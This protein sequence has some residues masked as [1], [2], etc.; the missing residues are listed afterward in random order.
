[1]SSKEYIRSVGE[2]IPD[3]FPKLEPLPSPIPS[4]SNDS[5]VSSNI[6]AYLLNITWQTWL[7]LFLIISLLGINIFAYLAKG[8]E[9]SATIIKQLFGP[10]LAF[11]GYGTLDTAKQTI[12][13]TATGTKAGVDIIAGAASGA[14]NIIEENVIANAIANANGQ[15]AKSSQQGAP[16]HEQIQTGTNTDKFE[17]GSL[18]K[19]LSSASQSGSSGPEPD[20]SRSSIQ[21]TGKA[22]WCFIGEDQGGRTCS[23]VGVNDTCMSGDVFPNQD[24]CM[25]P[26]LRA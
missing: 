7:I 8:T 23:Q 12:G 16:V 4:P 17:Q 14:V 25:N 19:A 13:T 2:M 6:S 24:I 1:M 15:M 21:S 5:T 10:I 11:F 26:N 3:D 9:E 22:G 18:E 20:N